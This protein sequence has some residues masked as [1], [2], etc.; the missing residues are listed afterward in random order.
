VK[1]GQIAVNLEKVDCDYKLKSGDVITNTFH[2]HEYP[3]LD[4]EVEIIHDSEDLL[5]VSKP[6]SWPIYPVS[7]YR[8]NS[9]VFIL[10]REHGYRNLRPIHRIDAG[11]SGIVI[12]AKGWEAASTLHRSWS[13]HS[14][15]KEYLALV[16]GRFPDG[17]V[18][19]D[20]PLGK[21]RLTAD[22]WRIVEDREAVTVFHLLQ[23]CSVT[24]TSL[25][26]CIPVTGRTHQIRL[27]LASLGHYIVKDYFYNPKDRQ[28]RT[29]TNHCD[30][31][32]IAALDTM[33]REVETE[34][35]SGDAGDGTLGGEMCVETLERQLS[36]YK[37]CL[38]CQAPN[39]KEVRHPEVMCLHSY[40][41]TIGEQVFES[42]L[43]SWAE[44]PSSVRLESQYFND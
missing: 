18:V 9:L 22:L 31:S 1:T 6:S 34:V 19:V 37:L 33:E 26:S 17:E 20:K 7:N 38:H 5:V 40:R 8:F 39:F 2:K 13:T 35:N 23:Y 21:Y 4:M 14:V 10:Y 36:P 16:D 11:T 3:V 32:V 41:Y 15:N 12:L 24:D 44:N 29:V 28:P 25:V 27:H 30:S 43:P 42:Q